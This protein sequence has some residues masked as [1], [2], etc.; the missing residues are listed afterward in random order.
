VSA[1][2]APYTPDLE[3]ALI[4]LWNRALDPRF[5]LGERLWRQNIEGDPNW[6]PGDA[7]VLR[8]PDAT[9]AGFAVTR[10]FRLLDHYPALAAVRD[11][12]WLTALV[13]A[14]EN[15]GRGLG[16]Q[17]LA[18]AEDQLRRHGATRCDIG[19][20]PG[21]LLPGPTAD[22]ERALRFWRRHGYEPARLVHDLHRS[23]ADWVPPEL[24]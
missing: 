24:R 11:L 1:T 10:R 12:G 23:L 3:T 21:H 4:A 17:L 2:I 13:I 8:L 14:P 18:A 22:D 7:L 20:S 5:P 16:T 6:R 9:L 19:G 15:S